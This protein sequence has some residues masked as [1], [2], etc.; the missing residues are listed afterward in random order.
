MTKKRIWLTLF[1]AMSLFMVSP[2]SAEKIS[3][4]LSFSL[5]TFS[6]GDLEGWVRSLN[7]LW[8]DYSALNPGSLTGAFAAPSYG[9]NFELELRIPIFRGFGLN[10]AGGQIDG[11]K[12]G[13]VFYARE[14]VDQE[15]TQSVLNDVSAFNLKIGLSYRVELPFLSGLHVFANAGRNLV[16]AKYDVKEK[17]Q[18]ILRISGLEFQSA[19]DKEDSFSSDAL[20]FYAGLGAEYDLEVEKVWSNVDGFKGSH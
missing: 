18:S 8:Q 4:K 20:G 3:L 17:W 6:E 13:A 16:F 7:S 2:L 10:L 1:F 5:N 9:S 15:Q 11:S 19:Y 14:G 12:E